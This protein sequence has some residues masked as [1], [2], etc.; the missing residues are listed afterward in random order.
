MICPL[1]VNINVERSHMVN[2]ADPD[3]VQPVIH[4]MLEPC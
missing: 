1:K 3:M 4:G 2:L